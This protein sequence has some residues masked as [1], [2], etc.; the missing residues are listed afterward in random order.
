MRR[1]RPPLAVNMFDEVLGHLPALPRTEWSRAEGQGIGIGPL[2]LWPELFLAV[3]ELPAP[4]AQDRGLGGL[5][6]GQGLPT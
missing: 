5:V 3:I 2:I 4:A 1:E 6:P